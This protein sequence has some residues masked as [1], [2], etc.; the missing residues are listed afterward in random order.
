M[1]MDSKKANIFMWLTIVAFF[2]LMLELV[3]MQLGFF[4]LAI[5]M[6]QVSYILLHW[7]ITCA[8]WGLGT[9]LLIRLAKRNGFDIFESKET[10]SRK[11]FIVIFAIFALITVASLFIWDGF[12]PL[13]QLEFF[14]IIFGQT[15]GMIALIAQ[16]VYYFFE[17]AVFIAIIALGQK[18]GE[19]IFGIER[20]PWGGIFCAL[21][22]GLV[23]IFTQSLAAGAYAIVLSIIYGIVYLLLKKNIRFAYPIIL[24]MFVL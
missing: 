6:G 11:N 15:D 23:H 1:E 17:T 8:F 14:Q 19:Y 21:S 10:A 24:L 5:A 9:W 20:V 2:I 3:V 16:Y 13:E 12:K 18:A 22:W 4:P 7:G